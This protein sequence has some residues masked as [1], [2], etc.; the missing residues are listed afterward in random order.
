MGFRVRAFG[1]PG[2]HRVRHFG[3]WHSGRGRSLQNFSSQRVLGTLQLAE[4]A[5]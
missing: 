1:I 4:V 3:V 5:S 2:V